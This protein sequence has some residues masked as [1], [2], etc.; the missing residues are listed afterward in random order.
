MGP[1]TIGSILRLKLLGCLQELSGF[2]AVARQVSLK[3]LRISLHGLQVRHKVQMRY[4][5]VLIGVTHPV[6]YTEED[7]VEGLEGLLVMQVVTD[8]VRAHGEQVNLGSDRPLSLSRAG[9]EL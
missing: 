2:L 8:L 5:E 3:A 9:Q 4:L 6:H 1:I 7:T